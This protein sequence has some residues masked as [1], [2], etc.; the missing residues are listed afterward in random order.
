M[1]T[2]N[3]SVSRSL[4][5]S[6]FRWLALRLL[7]GTRAHAAIFVFVS[8]MALALLFLASTECRAQTAPYGAVDG[9]TIT[10]V[11]GEPLNGGAFFVY[12]NLSWTDG[13]A[14]SSAAG[15]P[16][17]RFAIDPNTAPG[18]ATIAVVLTAWT[19]G[20]PIRIVGKGTCDIWGDT[21][22]VAYILT[23]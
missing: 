13:P 12:V 11:I 19:T 18:K 6:L 16:A 15:I 3:S 17:R 20:H 10:G 8:C 4:D 14:C 1:H 2:H 9:A 7:T 23:E 22:S 5:L 21:E